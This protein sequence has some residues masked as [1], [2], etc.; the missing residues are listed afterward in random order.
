MHLQVSEALYVTLRLPK[1]QGG[2]AAAKAGH[3]STA[4]AALQALVRSC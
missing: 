1:P 4:D 3:G 2:E